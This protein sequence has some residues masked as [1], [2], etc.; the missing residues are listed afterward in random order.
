MSGLRDNLT[1]IKSMIDNPNNVVL[2]QAT[3]AKS[4]S[5]ID[6]TLTAFSVPQELLSATEMKKL[7]DACRIFHAQRKTKTNVIAFLIEY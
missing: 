5:K 1:K 7:Y 2:R 6:Q 3:F 4:M